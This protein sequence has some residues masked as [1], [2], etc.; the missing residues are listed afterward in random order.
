MAV[1]LNGVGNRTTH[2]KHVIC[3]KSLSNFII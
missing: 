2:R 3:C 1:S